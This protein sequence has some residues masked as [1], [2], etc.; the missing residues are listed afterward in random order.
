MAETEKRKRKRARGIV[1]SDKMD[2]TVAV[3]VERL[4]KDRRTGKYVRRR[5]T[6]KAHDA[7]S[8]THEGDLVEI[9]QTRPLSK[10]KCWR[11]VRVLRRAPALDVRPET[12]E[13]G[14]AT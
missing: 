10:T 1:S 8:T 5:S 6:F 3:R 12:A 7:R 2:K 14:A 4:V 9:E 13:Q 11:L